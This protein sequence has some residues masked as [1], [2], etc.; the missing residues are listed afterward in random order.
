VP[1]A[2]PPNFSPLV[3][4]LQHYKLN[5]L[6]RDLIAGLSV[7]AVQVPTAVAYSQ[8]AGFSPEIGLYSSILPVIV[9]AFL[10]S[11]RQL[12]VGP[13]AATCAMVA[14]LVIPLAAGD[15]IRYVTIS[16]ALSLTAGL[17]MIVGGAARMGFIVNFFARPILIGFLNGIA[18]SII[19][20]QLGKL[21]GIPLTHRDFI[22]SLVE[23]SSKLTATHWM[24]LA[25]GLVTLAILLLL[26]RFAPKAPSSLIALAVATCGLFLI[27]GAASSGVALVGTVPS[28]LPH[29]SLPLVGY[30]DSQG[31]L[32][33][34]IGLVVVSFTSGMLTARSFAARS[35]QTIDPNQEMWAL[36]AA[37]VA[38]GLSGGFAI[39]GGDSRTAVNSASGNKTQLASVIAAVAT[40]TVAACLSAPLGYL[41][42]S[43][44]AA[45]LISSA[46]H[47]IDF[48]SYKELR[49]IDPFEFRLSLLTTAG[50]LTMGV[51]PGVAVAI[52]LALV[53]V[54]IKIYKPDDTILGKVPGLDG[55]NDICL[56]PE[57]KT[58]PGVIIWR[59]E[60]P[61]VF[62]NADYFVARARQV[63]QQAD[64]APHWFVLSLESISQTDATG[65]KAL[66]DL[67]TE[68]KK[69]DI[70][71]ILARP[72]PYMR[73]LRE[74][75]T[76]GIT[77]TGESIY[78]TIGAAVEAISLREGLAEG[79]EL[80]AR[81]GSYQRFYELRD[82]AQNPP[83][84][85]TT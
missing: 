4:D 83:D 40:A 27:G 34:A 26:R 6:P 16:A 63:I 48:S 30:H 18:A 41:P 67:L 56:S 69:R 24:T 14:S 28:G 66:E 9:Y 22:P 59:F 13:D 73:K 57:S 76:L 21:L 11:S 36:G 29:L 46:I 78:P 37:N 60:G 62:F 61:L 55:Y 32:V 79:E 47:L 38:A 17:L 31:L 35:G 68:M 7:A 23:L 15:P 54:L 1:F 77:L 65:I 8:L 44:L 19:A 3:S 39:T 5:W 20:G 82:S 12:V 50:V 51:L 49:H 70:R 10:G 43:A 72:K 74:H 45:V 71:L 42:L 64:P 75:T 81:S 33:S 52:T 58:V 2:F 25:V 80:V 53:I 84:K 85:P